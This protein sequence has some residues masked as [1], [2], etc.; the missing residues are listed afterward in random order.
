MIEK[1][2][3]VFLVFWG[4][5]VIAVK[6]NIQYKLGILA[7]KWQSK[8]LYEVSECQFCFEHHLAIIPTLISLLFFNPEW[9]DVFMPIMVAALSNL[10]KR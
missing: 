5:K 6:Y 2:I 4:L 9:K 10:L 8:V 3:F 7:N 1:L